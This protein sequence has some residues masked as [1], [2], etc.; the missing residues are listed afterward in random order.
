MKTRKKRTK[1][2]KK[3]IMTNQACIITD[4]CEEQNKPDMTPILP[5]D[6]SLHDG[7]NITEDRKNAYV[8]FWNA[9]YTFANKSNERGRQLILANI[10]DN[11]KLKK[12]KPAV[13]LVTEPDNLVDP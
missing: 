8:E 9:G 4:L 11:Y 12:L 10:L 1:S 2:P 7:T 3:K 13:R 5:R 6:F